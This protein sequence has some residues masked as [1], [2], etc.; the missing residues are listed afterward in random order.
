MRV[1][2][3]DQRVLGVHLAGDRLDRPQPVALV[4]QHRHRVP[5]SRFGT[6]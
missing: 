2:P 4:D 1:S 6:E 3:G 5:I